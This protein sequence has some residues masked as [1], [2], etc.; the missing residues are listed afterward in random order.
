MDWIGL[1]WM[2]ILVIVLR[3]ILTKG[4]SQLYLTL[5]TGTLVEYK[6]AWSG[7]YG[8]Y[9]EDFGNSAVNLSGVLEY[10]VTKLKT[11]ISTKCQ[12]V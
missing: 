2:N 7:Y 11:N 12:N 1:D 6:L 9:F 8:S 10:D 5:L 4:R 3:I